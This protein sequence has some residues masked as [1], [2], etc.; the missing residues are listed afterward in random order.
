MPNACPRRLAPSELDDQVTA[1][2]VTI[3]RDADQAT[4]LTSTFGPG[5]R[6]VSR[7]LAI[8]FVNV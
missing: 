7:S 3:M 6:L 8:E 1:L 5:F 4:R 2:V